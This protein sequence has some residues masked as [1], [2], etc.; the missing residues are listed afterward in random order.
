MS[1]KRLTTGGVLRCSAATPHARRALSSTPSLSSGEIDVGAELGLLDLRAD[2]GKRG[3]KWL[4][5]TFVDMHGVSKSKVVPLS[6]L[7]KMM[8]GSEQFTGAAL[9]GVPQVSAHG[10]EIRPRANLAEGGAE[11]R[12]RESRARSGQVRQHDTWPL[13]A[14]ALSG[15]DGPGDLPDPGPGLLHRP[16]VEARHRLV[17][18]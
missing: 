4:L 5:P 18:L 7:G 17:C 10:T 12:M 1:L 15:H 16:A 11:Q 9:D 3:V 8:K 2:L 13:A 14:T 6:H